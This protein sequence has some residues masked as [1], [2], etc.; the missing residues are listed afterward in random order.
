MVTLQL[1]VSLNTMVTTIDFLTL[2]G[3]GAVLLW[4]CRDTT[5]CKVTIVLCNGAQITEP[6]KWHMR[7]LLFAIESARWRSTT[8]CED[9]D[10]SNSYE[11]T[12]ES[13][14]R[15]ENLRAW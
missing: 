8:S 9:F 11:G 13:V 4:V 1:M 2:I 3:Y 10:M 6:R 7:T 15:L 5:N 14:V 12:H